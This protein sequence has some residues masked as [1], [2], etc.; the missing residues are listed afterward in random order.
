MLVYVALACDGGRRGYEC[1]HAGHIFAQTALLN[2][3]ENSLSK[4]FF[5]P[6]A[7]VVHPYIKAFNADSGQNHDVQK[8]SA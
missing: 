1:A 7:A 4:S 6:R 2:I 8:V 5:R 3:H